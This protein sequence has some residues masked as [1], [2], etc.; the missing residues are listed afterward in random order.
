MFC[1]DCV[2]S[3][4]KNA[5]RLG[6][7]VHSHP[8]DKKCERSCATR[9][10]LGRGW[11]IQLMREAALNRKIGFQLLKQ[12]DGMPNVNGSLQLQSLRLARFL[13]QG[14]QT[15]YEP[16]ATVD[17][18][19][20]YLAFARRLEEAGVP[21][22]ARAVCF[23]VLQLFESAHHSTTGVVNWPRPGEQPLALHSVV[24]TSLSDDG[25]SIRFRNSWGPGW[26]ARG[27]GSVDLEYLAEHFVESWAIWN[28]RWGDRWSKPEIS[29]LAT[30]RALRNTWM[31]ENPL[32]ADR[33]KGTRSGDTWIVERFSTY[34]L[35]EDCGVDAVQIRNGYGMRMGWGYLLELRDAT[36]TELREL[37]VMPAFRR[38]GLG[39]VL[40]GVSSD[41]AR[42][43]GSRHIR[44]LIHE[45][46]AGVLANRRAARE[47][48]TA[49]G[50]KLRWRSAA[51]PRIVGVAEK[52]L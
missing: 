18:L 52:D 41:L 46:D 29:A 28:A 6:W 20:E 9:G 17:K 12:L 47:F 11:Q 44:V 2:V 27:N 45:A 1:T 30:G 3:L 16:I 10:E 50:Y 21:A 7:D 4:L 23:M 31:M 36:V 43:V 8:L 33:L 48:L 38:Q 34:S 39:S 5:L 15:C 32:F 51:G 37:F 26:G 22:R 35:A 13:V 25:C 40:E 42:S 24:P 49:R 14:P 19:V